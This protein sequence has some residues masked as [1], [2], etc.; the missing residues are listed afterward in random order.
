MKQ[1]LNGVNRHNRNPFAITFSAT[2]TMA[3]ILFALTITSCQKGLNDSMNEIQSMN[4]KN[5]QADVLNSFGGLSTQT[6]WELQQARAATARY[7][8]FDNA[9]MDG[10]SDI[11][12]VVPNM[13]HHYMK[14]TIL[15]D[16]FDYKQPEILVYNKKEDGSMQLV[17]VE[18]AL[19]L[20]LSENAPQGFTGSGDV[21]DRNTGFG[22]WLLH[23][24][25]WNYNP[26]GVF[27]PLNPSVHTH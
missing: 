22:L 25:V 6:A 1:E 27:N 18:Y 23:A 14:A 5:T 3:L 11:N 20:N 21:W 7:R 15:D 13:G 4:A 12:V 2:I 8:N 17:A 9:I 24:W 26:N 16:K 19:P 10:Y